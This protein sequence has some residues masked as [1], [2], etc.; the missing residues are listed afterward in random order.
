[1][2]ISVVVAVV[3]IDGVEDD[4]RLLRRGGVVEID[5][6]MSPNLLR[7]QR[8]VAANGLDVV[9]RRGGDLGER[10]FD[11]AVIQIGGLPC[12]KAGL[13]VGVDMRAVPNLQC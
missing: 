13:S 7:Q 6:R 12:S 1:M 5:Q 3:L 11:G 4:L 9:V 2:D 8:E 10:G